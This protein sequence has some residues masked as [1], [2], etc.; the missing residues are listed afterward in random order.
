MVQKVELNSADSAQLEALPLIGEKLA[1]RIIRYRN[2]LGGFYRVEQLKEVYG[3]RDSAYRVIAERVEVDSSRI[4]RLAINSAS[5]GQ[6]GSHPYLGYKNAKLID[7]YRKEHG[8]IKNWSELM[9]IVG[10]QFLSGRN[11][12]IYLSFD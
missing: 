6:L 8:S 2:R 12:M 3:L 4:S 10:L 1:A 9:Q 11:Y 7:R 5:F